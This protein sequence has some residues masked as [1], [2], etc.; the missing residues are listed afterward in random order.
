MK[1]YAQSNLLYTGTHSFVDTVLVLKKDQAIKI[2]NKLSEV[3]TLDERLAASLKRESKLTELWGLSGRALEIADQ[4]FEI[5]QDKILNLQK[6]LDTCD[7]EIERLSGNAR[8]EK[9]NSF[10]TGTGVGV[11]L[12]L[13]AVIA[14]Q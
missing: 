9:R 4:A 12:A 2:S 14:L 1:S 7:K 11:V 3:N 5:Q 8:K 13:L 6:Q 10:L